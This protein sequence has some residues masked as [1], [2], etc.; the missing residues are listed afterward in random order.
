MTEDLVPLMTL[1]QVAI[2]L[3]VHE[4]TAYRMANKGKIP[5]F[6]VGGVWRCR[7]EDLENMGKDRRN[8]K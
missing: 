1:K 8:V 6:R 7:R 3:G 2:F 5:M 4:I